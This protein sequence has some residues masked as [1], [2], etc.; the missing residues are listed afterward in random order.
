MKLIIVPL[1]KVQFEELLPE[2]SFYKNKEKLKKNNN[3]RKII[4]INHHNN[5]I[6][7][8]AKINKTLN[9]CKR[10]NYKK[11]NLMKIYS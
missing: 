10:K 2:K 9:S 3:Y 6:N 7:K 11:K 1:L 5:K 4:K 8:T